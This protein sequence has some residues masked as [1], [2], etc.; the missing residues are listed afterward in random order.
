[1]LGMSSVIPFLPLYVRE[2]GITE[3]SEAKFWSGLILAGPFF[4]SLIFAPFW[5]SIGDKY[6]RKIM[7]VRA[8]VGL[9]VAVLM[10]GFVQNVY[11]LFA[12]RLLQGA[13]SGMIAAALAFTSTNTPEE[14]SGFA[15]GILQGSL[16]AGIIVGPFIGGVLSDLFGIREVFYLV[17][18]LCFM[19][20]I[21]ILIYVKEK[22]VKPAPHSG[23]A[24]I[25]NLK[26]VKN[27][28]MLL[29]I[30]ILIILSQAGLQFANPILPF[31][32]EQLKA[33]NKYLSTITGSLFAI[34]AFFSILFT[35]KWGKR[36]DKKD[37]RK[38]LRI[39]TLIIAIASFSQIFVPNY[40]YL[41]PLRAVIGIFYAAVIPTLYSAISKRVEPESRGGM[42]GLASSATT[43]GN[44]SSYVLCGM[45]ASKISIESAFVSSALLLLMVSVIT[46]FIK[47][48]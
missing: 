6:G 44:L 24:I 37:F 8:T 38:T 28:K 17:A 47:G 46:L 48:K 13:L 15:I 11:Q 12:M 45:V 4:L 34:V 33:P 27:N 9:S 22:F 36:N 1:M 39:A 7:I 21:L 14:K 25:N 19:S 41:Y 10:M 16:S 32:V 35:S 20:G 18:A 5:G 23:S 26:I 3:I 43:L 31:F 29:S 2:L 42:M 30:M 40:I